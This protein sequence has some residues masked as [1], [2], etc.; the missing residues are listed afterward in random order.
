[1]YRYKMFF[2]IFQCILLSCQ[3][4]KSSKER[5]LDIRERELRLKEKEFERKNKTGQPIKNKPTLHGETA[6]LSK[7]KYLF[8]VIVTNE[9]IVKTRI[10][11]PART[12]T[13]EVLG[14]S[15]LFEE[16]KYLVDQH[17]KYK[18]EVFKIDH[19]NEDK[20]FIEIDKYEY[21]IKRQLMYS[22]VDPSYGQIE[23]TILSRQAYVF[24]TYKEASIVRSKK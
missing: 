23:N 14:V 16:E 21:K 20:K 18:S 4:Q 6:A 24:D 22:N 15:P 2:L 12:F 11:Q 9:P 13:D 8:V 1:M 7:T 17:Y 3:N 10:K 19:Y 5:E